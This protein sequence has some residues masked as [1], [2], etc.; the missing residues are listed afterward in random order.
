MSKTV[1]FNDNST[2]LYG[3]PP[4]SPKPENSKEN[5]SLLIR[6][7]DD[8]VDQNPYHQPIIITPIKN[9]WGAEKRRSLMKRVM[10]AIVGRTPKCSKWF[11]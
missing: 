11:G 3:A 6:K 4:L 5:I 9:N 8:F 7:V 1:V 10:H 2:C